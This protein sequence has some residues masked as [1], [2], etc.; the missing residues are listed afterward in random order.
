MRT[1]ANVHTLAGHTNT[2]ASVICQG[3]EPQ[4]VFISIFQFFL[5]V[6]TKIYFVSY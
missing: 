6:K 5:N 2:V 4:V 1:K 3:V